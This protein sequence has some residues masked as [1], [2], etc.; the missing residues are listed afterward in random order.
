MGSKTISLTCREVA[1]DHLDGSP[2]RLSDLRAVAQRCAWSKRLSYALQCVLI[3]SHHEC[4]GS[5]KPPCT[6]ELP[7]LP[8]YRQQVER[9]RMAQNSSSGLSD[10]TKRRRMKCDLWGKQKRQ[11]TADNQLNLKLTPQNKKTRQLKVTGRRAAFCASWAKVIGI[12]CMTGKEGYIHCT[13][14]SGVS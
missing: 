6:L 3:E 7:R 14:E 1:A 4:R 9:T 10:T 11:T 2:E 5:P 13:Y 12:E 8:R